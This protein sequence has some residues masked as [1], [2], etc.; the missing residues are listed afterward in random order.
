MMYVF[1]ERL[2]IEIIFNDFDAVLISI[3]GRD[4]RTLANTGE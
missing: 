4:G 3:L 1:E 2:A